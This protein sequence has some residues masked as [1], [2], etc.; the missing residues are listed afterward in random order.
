MTADRGSLGD[1]LRGSVRRR[2]LAGTAHALGGRLREKAYSREEHVWYALDLRERPRP[3]MPRGLEL[4]RLQPGQLGRLEELPNHA[5]HAIEARQ[6]DDAE[7]WAV[8]EA[9][10]PAFACWIFPTRTPVAAARDGW[11]AVPEATVCLEHSVTSPA[12]RGRGV[13]PAA[14]AAVADHVG[15]AGSSAMITKV[16]SDNLPSRRAVEKAGF[17][18]VAAMRLARLGPRRRVRVERRPDEPLAD[19][20]AAR[21]EA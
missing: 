7:L 14:W 16:S 2:G 20:L 13:A 10:E 19:E 9:A 1:R 21:L 4:R 6:A 15:E 5:A 3:P 8:L 18:E 12:Y 17:R 11:L